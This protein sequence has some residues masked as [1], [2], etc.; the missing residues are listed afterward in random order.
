[1]F[2]ASTKVDFRHKD[3]DR[4]VPGA[5]AT[6][7]G[8]APPPTEAESKEQV[9]RALSQVSSVSLSAENDDEFTSAEEGFGYGEAGESEAVPTGF[10]HLFLHG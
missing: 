6:G 1:M 9:L 3:L 7:C 8:C 2:E 5:V 10:E 4:S